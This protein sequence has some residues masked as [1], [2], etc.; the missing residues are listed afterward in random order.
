MLR[1]RPGIF[2]WPCFF[3]PMRT[4]T[5]QTMIWGT[6]M[7]FTLKRSTALASLAQALKT[8]NTK[9]VGRADSEFLFREADGALTVT[10]LNDTTEQTLT[11][12]VASMNAEP[13][14]GFS[15]PGQALVDLIKDFPD[16]DVA[17]VYN[18]DANTIL[19][20]GVAKKT[21]FRFPT[22]DPDEFMPY[23]Y[24]PLPVT[25]EVSGVAL[26]AALRA[27]AFA[28]AVDNTLAP[29]TAVRVRLS[30][31]KLTAESTDNSRISFYEVTV[32]D[33]GEED[34]EM[35]LPRL[36]ADT[37]ASLLEKVPKVT[38]KPGKKHLRVEWADTMFT[39]SLEN[40][41]GKPFPNLAKHIKAPAVATATVSRADLARTIKLAGLVVKDSYLMVSVGDTD[42]F[43][44]K[45][46]ENL[47]VSSKEEL[48]GASLDTVSKQDG[49]GTASVLVSHAL[50][51]KAVDMSKAAWVRVSF[52]EVKKDIITLMVSDDDYNHLM[53]PINPKQAD[54]G[55]S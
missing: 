33:V 17:C 2:P 39:C 55:A 48:R 51:S 36:T 11:L 45:Y 4:I 10:S 20:K 9:A 21:Q 49:T 3:W 25:V 44:G 27:T 24:E 16:D 37:L 28:T 31:D 19:V 30:H 14:E 46:G 1:Q 12:P 52:V 38:L 53:F 47:V 5:D 34:V 42:E 22:G 18:K 6:D 54:G 40:E 13:G 35:L 32:A 50:L 23:K 8:C 29:K 15:A 7:D 26:A 43:L 41:L